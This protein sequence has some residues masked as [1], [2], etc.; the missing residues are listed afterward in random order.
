LV[1]LKLILSVQKSITYW[2]IVLYQKFYDY[3][4]WIEFWWSKNFERKFS[5]ERKFYLWISLP[6]NVRTVEDIF[7]YYPLLSKKMAYEIL[8]IRK[9]NLKNFNS[10]FKK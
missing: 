10:V 5:K 1:F 6:D 8:A 9:D 7:F 3:I 4:K 2:L